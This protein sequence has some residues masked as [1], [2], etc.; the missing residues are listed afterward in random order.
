MGFSLLGN[1]FIWCWLVYSHHIS[2]QPLPH[3]L[4]FLLFICDVSFQFGF[5]FLLLH[6]IYFYILLLSSSCIMFSLG[7]ENSSMGWW[8]LVYLRDEYIMVDIFHSI[9]FLYHETF[10]LTICLGFEFWFS[11]AVAV[12]PFLSLTEGQTVIR[13]SWRQQ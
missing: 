9:Y 13:F 4:S 5:V 10:R 12:V 3:C 6:V 2:Q 1:L 8:R 7:D 11:E